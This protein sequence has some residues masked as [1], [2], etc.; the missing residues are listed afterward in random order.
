MSLETSKTENR[1]FSVE[2]LVEKWDQRN[3][4]RFFQQGSFS[5]LFPV[6]F[7]LQG[8]GML[9]LHRAKLF[10]H[11][12]FGSENDVQKWQ[13]ELCQRKNWRNRFSKNYPKNF[14]SIRIESWRFCLLIFVCWFGKQ[15][16]IFKECCLHRFCLYVFLRFCL[17]TFS[18]IPS[19]RLGRRAQTMHRGDLQSWWGPHATYEVHHCDDA[20]TRGATNETVTSVLQ[21]IRSRSI[22]GT[23]DQSGTVDLHCERIHDERI[24]K[25]RKLERLWHNAIMP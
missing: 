14:P 17:F 1:W 20:T 23:E 2:C 15:C 24:C 5:R 8:R 21:E 25:E 22:I 18:V 13:Y 19:S 9:S 10:T 6:V 11:P 4:R 3:F 16:F 12:R 7:R